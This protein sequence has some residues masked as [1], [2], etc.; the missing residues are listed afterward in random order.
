MK[1]KTSGYDKIFDIVRCMLL[2]FV[3]IIVLYPIYFV[4]I[5]SFLTQHW[6]VQGR[7]FFC[8]REQALRDTNKSLWIPVYGGAGSILCILWCWELCLICF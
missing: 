3:M 5:A 7:L 4:Y 6:S 2:G 1:I 8:L